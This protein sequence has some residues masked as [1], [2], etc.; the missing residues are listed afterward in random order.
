M[1]QY[2]DRADEADRR[3]LQDMDER[4]KQKYIAAKHLK[5]DGRPTANDYR[6]AL[7]GYAKD[8]IFTAEERKTYETA[9]DDRA[10]RAD[11]TL[12]RAIC[13][14]PIR[15]RTWCRRR[16]PRSADT[17][18]L[19][20]GELASKGEKVEPG[21]LQASR[22]IEPAKIP[23]AGGSSGRRLALA[24]WIASPDNPLTARVMVN[25]LWQHHFGEGIVRTPSDFG[26]NGDRPSHPELLDW[27]ATQFVE[28]K[29][30]MKAMHRLMLLSN[31]YRQSTE[32][33]D[34]AKYAEAD[35][36]NQLLWRMNWM[37]L[38]GEAIRDSHARRSAANCRS[39]T[40]APAFSSS[41]PDDVA[42]GLRVLQVV[43]VGR[44]GAG[45]ADHLHLPAPLGHEADDRSLRRREHERSLLPAQRHR[46]ADAGV[47]AV[48]QRIHAHRDAGHFADR[49]V[50]IGRPGSRQADRTGVSARRWPGGPPTRSA[51]K[52]KA[53]YSGKPAAESL[54]Q[55]AW[56]C[57]T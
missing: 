50:E 40:A 19:A 21:F 33:P 46:G 47:L 34:A 48:E 54:A 45:A 38:E 27:L 57:S 28:K 15:C 24:E 37:R 11:A 49:V 44:E 18:V 10:K 31:T 52:Y 55:L 39:R 22:A 56:C 3:R 9:R 29:W 51:S 41:I 36:K 42:G 14:W 6:K 16:F 8:P 12:G 32:N 53:L 2:E 35:P 26:I 17:Y 7:Q 25:R 23:F 1:R 43:P 30:S 5:P 13:P 4:F 20:G